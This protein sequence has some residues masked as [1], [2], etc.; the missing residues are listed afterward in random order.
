MKIGLILAL[1]LA[2]VASGSAANDD[3]I[4]LFS[5]LLIAT[6]E[7]G[8]NATIHSPDSLVISGKDDYYYNVTLGKDILMMA[9]R[10]DSGTIAIGADSMGYYFTNMAGNAA[11]IFKQ[12]PDRFKKLDLKL[13]D[14]SNALIAHASLAASNSTGEVSSCPQKTIK[15]FFPDVKIT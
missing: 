7:P 5:K 15:P 8:L 10:L 11:K 1:A 13:Y 4:L 6:D 12:Y 9:K 3:E 2:L 14:P